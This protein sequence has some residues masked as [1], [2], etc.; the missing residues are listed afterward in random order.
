MLTIRL[1]RTGKKHQPYFRIV[2]A[3]SRRHA[4]AKTIEILGNF[5]PRSKKLI[6][7]EERIRFRL[8][9]GAQLSNR[10]ARLLKNKIKCDKIVVKDSPPAKPKQKPKPEEKMAVATPKTENSKEKAAAAESVPP[11]E[12]TESIS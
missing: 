12:K 2:A 10:L 11:T 3:D 6:F 9:S 1:Q 8:E 5:D 7:N 4:T